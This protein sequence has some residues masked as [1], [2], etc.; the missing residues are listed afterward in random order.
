M[1]QQTKPASRKNRKESLAVPA[2]WLGWLA[3]WPVQIAFLALAI[4]LVYYHTLDVPFYLDD[5]S[6]IRENTLIYHWQGVD[7]LWQYAPLR[8]VGYLTIALNYHLHQFN[9]I[10]YHLVNIFIHILASCA[11][12][13]FMRGLLRTPRLANTLSPATKVWLPLLTALFFALHPLQIQGVTYIVQ[14]LASLAALF[15]I[16]AMA[17]YLQARLSEGKINTNKDSLE[18]RVWDMPQTDFLKR[19]LWIAVCVFFALLGF[20]TK[21][22]TFTL[23]FAVVMLEALFF[24]DSI[25]LL[26]TIAAVVLGVLAAAWLI[27]V[28]AFDY[29]PLSLE[30]MQALT[31]ETTQ[32]S[33]GSY[34]ATQLVVLWKYIR[35]FFMPVGLHIDYDF[36]PLSG[37]AEASVV[38]SLLAHLAV[39]ALALF[40]I[41][42]WPL[43][44]FALLFYYLAHSVE[45]SVI[46]IRDVIFEHRTYLPNLGLCVFT[47]WL[48]LEKIPAWLRIPAAGSIPVTVL[49]LFIFGAMTSLRNEVWRDPIKLWQ[50][51][52][53]LSPGKPR[54]WSILG[55]HMLQAQPPRPKEGVKALQQSLALQRKISESVN[56]IDIVNLIV[57]LKM[58]RKYNEALKLT[59]RVMTQKMKP[60]MRA[61]FL[62][63]RGN[64][65]F[66]QS[67]SLPPKTPDRKKLGQRLVKAAEISYRQAIKVFPDS[68]SA[69]ANLASIM[70]STGRYADAEALYLEV[71]EIDPDNRVIQKNLD[72][73]RG[74]MQ[75]R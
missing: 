53:E 59:E 24:P 3:V 56:I 1:Q 33:R 69:R 67:R 16:A 15:Y 21:Q 32:I 72:L 20:F 35:L 44:A 27:V 2:D 66:E 42:R 6:S 65:Y 5:F 10:G 64:I 18:I 43:L 49:L 46:P 47:G 13:G 63:N 14:R 70:G 74:Q 54:A 38:I 41:R 29:H 57:G 61:K 62:I 73:I 48:L 25:K 45:S 39:L 34:L 75:T 51:N 8:I 31:R 23:L 52:V 36:T 30:A 55:K 40:S 26:A 17:A 58:L 7:A 50:N 12:F 9:T 28:A 22:N 37:F 11:V 60:F 4:I 71:L 19:G 68:L